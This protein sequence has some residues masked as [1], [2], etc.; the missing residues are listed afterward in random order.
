MSMA[1]LLDAL[2]TRESVVHSF[3][4]EDGLRATNR[5]I[6]PN[7]HN[8]ARRQRQKLDTVRT[9]AAELREFSVAELVR[10]S[11]STPGRVRE[12]MKNLHAKQRVECADVRLTQAGGLE[13]VWR[14]VP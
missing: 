5:T 9:K 2:I 12:V 11:G 14:W 3:R 4:R 6:N 10:A 1:T 13:K 7:N 8:V